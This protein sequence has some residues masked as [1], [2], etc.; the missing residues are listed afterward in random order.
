M[1]TL[2]SINRKFHIFRFTINK[3]LHQFQTQNS[4]RVVLQAP[5]SRPVSVETVIKLSL[6]IVLMRMQ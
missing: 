4:Y 6:D 2:D 5:I 3:G 1:I